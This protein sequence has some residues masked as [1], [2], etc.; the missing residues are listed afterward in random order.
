MKK[1]PFVSFST[2]H[3]VQR[4]SQQFNAN[5]E[6][7]PETRAQS[8]T[9]PRGILQDSDHQELLKAYKNHV[10]H[11]SPT[12][13][14]YYYQF[15]TDQESEKD[16]CSRNESQVVTKSLLERREKGSDSWRLLR[17]NQLWIWTLEDSKSS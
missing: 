10:I 4:A 11:F 15:A 9:H 17:V 7:G 1:M 14:E 2:Y 12:L 13:D 8:P 16:R 6:T 5:E 3:D